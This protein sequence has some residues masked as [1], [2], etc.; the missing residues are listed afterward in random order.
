MSRGYE[1]S[2]QAALGSC[3]FINLIQSTTLW[4]LQYE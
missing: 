4:I 2:F 1:L 3:S